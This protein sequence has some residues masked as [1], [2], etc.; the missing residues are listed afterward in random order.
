MLNA[1]FRFLYSSLRSSF[2]LVK[3]EENV[4]FAS[5]EIFFFLFFSSFFFFF[6]SFN[7]SLVKIE[8][9]IDVDVQGNLFCVELSSYFPLIEFSAT[10][11]NHFVVDRKV[12]SFKWNLGH[13]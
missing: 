7:F 6:A 1:I 5:C 3:K 4:L 9:G 8:N 12:L 11:L 2:S 13:F 10:L